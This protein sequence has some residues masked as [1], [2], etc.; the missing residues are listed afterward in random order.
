MSAAGIFLEEFKDDR[1]N[2][3]QHHLHRVEQRCVFQ[4]SGMKVCVEEIAYHEVN[5]T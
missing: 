3:L 2:V 5:S 4:F 1:L